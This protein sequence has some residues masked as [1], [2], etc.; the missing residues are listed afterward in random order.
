M[1]PTPP[2][3]ATASRRDS[4]RR[5]RPPSIALMPDPT[6]MLV[7]VYIPTKNRLQL[8]SAAVDS[9]LA[10]T[11]RELELIVVDDGST[12][13]TPAYL[14]E[15][16]AQDPRLRFL[17]HEASRGGP[18]AR[19]AAIVASRGAF[20]TGLD[21]DDTFEP[22]R[23]EE[24]VRA[25]QALA[26]RGER[27]SC[28][29]SQLKEIQHGQHVRTSARPAMASYE[30]MFRQNVV[31]NQ[32]F[33]PKAHYVEAGLFRVDL[34]AWQDLEFFMR[35]L[36]SFGPARLVD[37]ASYNFE[38]SPRSDRISAQGENKLR[39]AY[40]LVDAAHSNG[41]GRRSQALYLQLFAKVYGIRPSMAD[42]RRFAALGLWPRGLARLLRASLHSS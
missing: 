28:L 12:D 7:T 8:L 19:N 1:N 25:W 29:Y 40:A 4:A 15:K 39:V 37:C 33:A 16:A 35:L 13:G 31:G 10:Q 14:A 2:I 3:A 26:A 11:H 17:R 36:R 22:E 30:D 21:D 9:V 41:I 38:N 34:P 23:I 27:P 32:I 18:A 20:V 6:T 24:F 5:A 42:F